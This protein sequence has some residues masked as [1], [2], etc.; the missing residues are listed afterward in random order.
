MAMSEENKQKARER[1]KAMHEAKKAA[2]VIPAPVKIN[3]AGH[4]AG[5]MQPSGES[6]TRVRPVQLIT[7]EEAEADLDRLGVDEWIK[8]HY[9]ASDMTIDMMAEILRETRED[10]YNRLHFLGF[11]LPE[12]TYSVS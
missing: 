7:E 12:G 8:K 6:T 11:P 2:P 10:M 1:M 3:T 4:E 9:S 5:I